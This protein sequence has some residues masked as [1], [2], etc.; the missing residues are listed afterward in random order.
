[1]AAR[2]RRLYLPEV[3]LFIGP[4]CEPRPGNA[5]VDSRAVMPSQPLL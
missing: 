2:P 5:C 1:V 3:R 4:D